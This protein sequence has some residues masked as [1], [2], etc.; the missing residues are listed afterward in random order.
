MSIRVRPSSCVGCGACVEVCPGNLLDL[1]EPAQGAPKGTRRQARIA[2][3]ADCWGCTSCL[4]A[5]RFGAVEF[6]LGADVGGT[7]A[8]LGFSREGTVS[9]WQVDCPDGRSV[10]IDVD[11]ASANK[12]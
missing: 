2:R 5:C 1:V 12:Y 9:H 7:G 6:F 3:P 11:G 4:K 8:T 10:R